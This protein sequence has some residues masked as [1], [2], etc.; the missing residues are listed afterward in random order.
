MEP[1]AVHADVRGGTVLREALGFT[2]PGVV[3]LSLLFSVAAAG[4]PSELAAPSETEEPARRCTQT[5][6][7]R[8]ES[9]PADLEGITRA[10][11]ALKTRLTFSMQQSTFDAERALD[12][13]F[14]LGLPSCRGSQARRVPLKEPIPAAYRNSRLLFM[15]AEARGSSTRFEELA[16]NPGTELLLVS[17]ARLRDMAGLSDSWGRRVALAPPQLVRVLGI[18]CASTLVTFTEAGDEALLAEGD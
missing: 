7:S 1:N 18:R 11:A 17:V 5:H 4:S 16:K 6:V 8:G 10:Y 12:R 13:P 14:D 3:A 15:K 2:A 9:L